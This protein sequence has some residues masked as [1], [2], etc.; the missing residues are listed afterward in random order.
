MV[1]KQAGVGTWECPV[2]LWHIHG[3][4]YMVVYTWWCIHGGVYMVAYTWW[5]IHGGVYI[6][7]TRTGDAQVWSLEENE[8]SNDIIFDISYQRAT[9]RER[10]HSS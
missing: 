6:V 4:V 2:P 9:A 1:P 8:N 10:A 5:R 3:G 7:A